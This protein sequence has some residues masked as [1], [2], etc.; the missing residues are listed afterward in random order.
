MR[1]ISVAVS[2]VLLAGCASTGTVTINQAEFE[3]YLADEPAE[4]E[5]GLGNITNLESD[6]GMLFLFQDSQPHT[7]WMKDVE[8]PIDIIWINNDK[9]VGSVTAYPG[10]GTYESPQSVDT[11]LEVPA[12]TA[13]IQQIEVGDNVV[14]DEY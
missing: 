7:F 11:V 3:V 8:Y 4:H 5:L 2:L 9:V 1:L 6:Q 13:A 12:E 10:P 14:V